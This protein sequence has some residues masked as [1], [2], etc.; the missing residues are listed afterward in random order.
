MGLSTV[1]WPCVAERHVGGEH[2]GDHVTL[3]S[4]RKRPW[5]GPVKMSEAEKSTNILAC[6]KTSVF[7]VTNFWAT[8][9]LCFLV[10]TKFLSVFHQF[11]AIYCQFVGLQPSQ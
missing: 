3:R 8:P 7:D 4:V 9:K 1:G 6:K 10:H 2:G 5:W 11:I